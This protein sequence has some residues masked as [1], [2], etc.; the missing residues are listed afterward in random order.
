MSSTRELRNLAPHNNCPSTCRPCEDCASENRIQFV[1]NRQRLH[2][3]RVV[4]GGRL[5][6]QRTRNNELAAE[7]EAALQ[8]NAKLVS[9]FES[10]RKKV[11]EMSS[12]LS[13]V[14]NV[15]RES[16]QVLHEQRVANDDQA[17]IIEDLQAHASQPSINEL[18]DISDSINAKSALESK[19]IESIALKDEQLGRLTECANRQG[20]LILHNDSLISKQEFRIGMLKK[21]IA[22]LEGKFEQLKDRHLQ[23][24]SEVP[25]RQPEF[26]SDA[27]TEVDE[28]APAPVCPK[29]PRRRIVPTL[30]S[31]GPGI[32]TSPFRPR[33]STPTPPS[34]EPLDPMEI[35]AALDHAAPANVRVRLTPRLPPNNRSAYKSLRALLFPDMVATPIKEEPK[36]RKASEESPPKAKF[37]SLQ[38]WLSRREY[39]EH[40]FDDCADDCS[41]LRGKSVPESASEPS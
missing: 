10:E 38:E 37:S 24:I 13:S 1:R 16:N 3:T 35:E 8:R 11:R 40:Y 4:L 19:L 32:P 39:M 20:K 15:L 7:L 36:K 6:A 5:D 14:M 30:L 9:D 29:T 2:R 34:S 12:E 23:V 25:P 18:A 17:R 33:P 28:P 31:A 41:S 26:D 22:M 21:N 27:E